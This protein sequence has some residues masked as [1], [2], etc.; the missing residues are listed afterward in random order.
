MIIWEE[1]NFFGSSSESYK[2]PLFLKP[3]FD[4]ISNWVLVFFDS[5]NQDPFYWIKSFFAIY[6]FLTIVYLALA[7]F[8]FIVK[9][10]KMIFFPLRIGNVFDE[11]Y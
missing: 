1:F 2:L 5:F 9:I 4:K 6:L 8:F 10:F 3:L 11:S 7:L